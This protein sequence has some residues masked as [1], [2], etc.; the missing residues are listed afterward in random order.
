MKGVVPFWGK[1]RC[2]SPGLTSPRGGRESRLAELVEHGSRV[3]SEEAADAC[4]VVFA[5]VLVNLAS[6]KAWGD[7]RWSMASL[8]REDS[9]K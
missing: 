9:L 7:G 6:A 1:E 4:K 3:Q 8:A 5:T 2:Y